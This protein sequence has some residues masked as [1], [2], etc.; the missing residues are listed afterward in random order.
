MR[1]WVNSL[2]SLYWVRLSLSSSSLFSVLFWASD[3]AILLSRSRFR[4]CSEVMTTAQCRLTCSHNSEPNL[5]RVSDW[6]T[7]QLFCLCKIAQS[8]TQRIKRDTSEGTTEANTCTDRGWQPSIPYVCT[9]TTVLRHCMSWPE[10][11]NPPTPLCTVYTQCYPSLNTHAH[12]LH[13]T[14]GGWVHCSPITS[15][16]RS[17]QWERDR[18]SVPQ[19]RSP[20]VMWGGRGSVANSPR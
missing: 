3:V 16:C 20:A 18:R 15:Y 13:C 2:A 12:P 6:I 17:I 5:L 19:Q 7:V 11:R 10:E 4:L 9:A 14:L 8:L 1:C